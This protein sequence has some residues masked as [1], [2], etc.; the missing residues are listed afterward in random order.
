MQVVLQGLAIVLDSL[1]L[2]PISFNY[3]P[4]ELLRETYGD[5]KQLLK[6]MKREW[7]IF[8]AT[9]G[10][11]ITSLKMRRDMLSAEGWGLRYSISFILL[12]RIL[13]SLFRIIISY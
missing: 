10:D 11:F 13:D 4:M 2:D 3:R 7:T 8:K 1:G 5:Y 6:T 9:R 12:T